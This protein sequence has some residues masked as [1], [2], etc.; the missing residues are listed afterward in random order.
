VDA[1]GTRYHLLLGEADWGACADRDRPPGDR[2]APTL[3]DLWAADPASTA[4]AWNPA[5]AELTLRPNLYRFTPPASHQ[6]LRPEDRRGAARDRYGNWYW[7]APSGTEILVRS[8]GTSATS[9]FWSAGDGLACPDTPGPGEFGP[10]APPPQPQALSLCGL[11]VTADH[12][13]AVGVRATDSPPEPAGLLVFDLHAGGPPRRFLWPAEV[14]FAPFDLAPRPG[15]GVWVLDRD[16]ARYWATDRHFRALRDGQADVPLPAPPDGFR[17]VAGPAPACR[18]EPGFPAGIDLFAASPLAARDPVAIEGLPDGTVLVLDRDPGAPFSRVFRYRFAEQLGPPASLA[19]ITGVLAADQADGFTL[20]AHDFAFVPGDGAPDSDRIDVADAAGEQAFAFRVADG[21]RGL[22]LTAL[23]DYLPMRLFGGKALVTAGGDVYYDFADRWVPLA[24]QR[25]PR[26]ADEAELYTPLGLPGDLASPPGSPGPRPA[27]DG[28]DPGCVWHRLLIDACLP[29]E[30]ELLVWS[31]AADDAR[32]LARAGWRPEPAPYLRGDG[33][34]LPYAPRRTADR[35]GTWELLFQRAVGRFLQLKLVLCGNGR[36][37]PRLRALRAYYPRFS[38][39]TRYLPAV[40]REDAGSAS[41]L[42]R[43][44]ANPEGTFT[45]T[46]DRVAAVQVL[47]DPDAAPAEALPWLARWFG[48]ALDPVWDEARRRLFLKH[49]LQVFQFRGT[50]LGLELAL[51]LALEPCADESLFDPAAPPRPRGV[52]VVEQFRSRRTPGVVPGDVSAGPFPAPPAA[53]WRPNQGG[54][55]LHRRYGEF[56]GV[57]P[58]QPPREFPVRRPADGAAAWEQFCTRT[59]GFVPQA[60]DDD[61]DRWRDFL[62][63]RYARVA[64][65]D[66]AYLA[67]WRSFA[68]VPL[69]AALPPDGPALRDW[70]QFEA[71]ALATQRA[72]HRFTVLL[73]AP[74]QDTPDRA[75]QQRRLELARRVIDLEKPAHTVFDVKFYWA[76]FRVGAVR[77]G[78]DS[79]IDRGSRSPELLPPAVLGRGFVG[80]SFVAPGHPQDVTDRQVLGRD[81]LGRGRPLEGDPA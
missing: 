79:V 33:S 29:P 23:A 34:E 70:Y 77:L 43:F 1:N 27:F 16:H 46:E 25:R 67:G 71:V 74:R 3:R 40:Y 26:Y 39:L 61:A 68:E 12:Y 2:P 41:F 55:A 64:A 17:P 14:R 49:A 6:R 20:T 5:R 48:V 76:Y 37:T 57:A 60:R 78:D 36:A 47:F 10:V 73:P 53:R 30:T 8:D 51:R 65:L 66:Q 22:V 50:V 52:R 63:R 21:G 35:D 72:A 31:R 80:G 13:L 45:A 28:R 11:A 7:I 38:Y 81:R 56:L 58:G 9:H 24:A 19:A 62:A 4:L 32:D 75:E 15:G 42:D 44:L 54:L 59:L 69:P 18:T